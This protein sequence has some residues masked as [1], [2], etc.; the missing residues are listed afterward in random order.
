MHSGN[1]SAKCAQ[2]HMHARSA[3]IGLGYAP[4]SAPPRLVDYF[5]PRP[6][7]YGSIILLYFVS[8]QLTPKNTR[9]AVCVSLHFKALFM[10]IDVEHTRSA[11]VLTLHP[12]I[13]EVQLCGEK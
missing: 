2:T 8:N 6:Q 10:L 3:E 11:S 5:A 12:M 13:V 1:D 9:R 7:M 4:A